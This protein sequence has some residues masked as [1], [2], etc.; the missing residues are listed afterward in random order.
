MVGREWFAWAT[1]VD[2]ND[3]RA[4]MTVGSDEIEE[5]KVGEM[6]REVGRGNGDA[7]S[8]EL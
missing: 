5:M 7:K 4:K 1:N 6:E 8:S 3:A 2:K